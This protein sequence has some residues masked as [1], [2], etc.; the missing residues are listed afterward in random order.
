MFY[1]HHSSLLLYLIVRSVLGQQIP[2]GVFSGKLSFT[3][4]SFFSHC[5]RL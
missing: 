3:H 5:T 1:K 4:L 2:P